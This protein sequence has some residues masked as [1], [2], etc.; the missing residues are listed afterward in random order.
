MPLDEETVN[1]MREKRK[2]LPASDLLVLGVVMAIAV[3]VTVIMVMKY[4]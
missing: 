1:E 2:K 4:G 3:V